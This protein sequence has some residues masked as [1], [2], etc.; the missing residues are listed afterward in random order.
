MKV[1]PTVNERKAL[2][3]GLE[4]NLP[5]LSSEIAHTD[6]SGVRDSPKDK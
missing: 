1:G 4:R 6:V 5:E 3:E 2:R